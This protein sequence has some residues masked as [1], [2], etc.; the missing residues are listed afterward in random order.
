M[1]AH[2]RCENCGV[3][4]LGIVLTDADPRLLGREDCPECG[5]S[6][7]TAVTDRADGTDD[8]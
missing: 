1:P 7:V 6:E 2:V 5:G 3:T 8:E 4:L